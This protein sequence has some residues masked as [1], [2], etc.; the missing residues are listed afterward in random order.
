MS[1]GKLP[2]GTENVG[3]DKELEDLCNTLERS[4]KRN[5]SVGLLR[6]DKVHDLLKV[7]EEAASPFLKK[8]RERAVTPPGPA[9]ALTMADFKAYMAENTNKSID[10]LNVKVAGMSEKL[11][12]V[13][14]SVQEH[15]A[16][17]DRH[18]AT[19]KANQS[20]IAQIKA[21]LMRNPSAP[22]TARPPTSPRI[23]IGPLD[24]DFLKARRS[25]RL[26]P[27]RGVSSLD[28]WRGQSTSCG[29]PSSCQRSLM[30]SLRLWIG[31]PDP[32]D[33]V[34]LMR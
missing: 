18:E 21:D 34:C 11:Q 1:E 24:P 20:Q 27:V 13:D 15:S 31:H 25:L 28:L 33:P 16:K 12:K 2:S 10:L 26:W 14:V 6:G 5:L 7:Q 9:M 22:T 4:R 30:T 17:L 8:R 32:L 29:A 23:S 19:I 3:F